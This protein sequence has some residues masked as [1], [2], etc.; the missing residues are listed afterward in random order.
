MFTKIWE[1]IHSYNRKEGV[2]SLREA[3]KELK[4]PK[5]TI[6]YQ[7]KRNDKREKAMETDYW[8]TAKGQRYLK[9]MIISTIYTF[10][11]KGGVGSERI[12]EHFKHLGL[13]E[14]AAVSSRTIHRMIKE[15]EINILWYKTLEE[16]KL[17]KEAEQEMEDLK[18]TL[19]LD[20][21]WLE[22][23]LLVCQDLTSGYLFLR[24]QAKNETGKAG[25]NI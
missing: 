17:K 3:E 5:S 15:I 21:T 6:A 2:I 8:N 22:E 23:M 12:A 18:A 10:A 9:K 11:I 16:K 25:G 13:G 7:E 24:S 4:I 20:E 19:G 14:I 1:K